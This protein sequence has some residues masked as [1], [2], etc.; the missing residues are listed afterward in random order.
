L[1]ADATYNLANGF[2]AIGHVATSLLVGKVDANTDTK[3][4]YS[5]PAPIGDRNLDSSRIGS[6]K[7]MR[8]IPT[9]EAKV[10]LGYNYTFDCDS[11]VT[12]EGGYKATQYID[13]VDRLKDTG[14]F[15]RTTSSLGFAGPYVK[16]AVKL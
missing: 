14:S 7:V 3:L 9:L 6:K 4:I 5:F 12:L 11:V 16:L 15:T 10:G 13:A 8:V 2:A 1:G